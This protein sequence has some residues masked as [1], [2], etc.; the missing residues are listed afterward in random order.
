M[1]RWPRI[2]KNLIDNSIEA[3]YCAIELHNKPIL[4][5]RYETCSILMINAWGLALRAYLYQVA[6]DKEMIKY[7]RRSLSEQKKEIIQRID[8]NNFD[9]KSSF[10][11]LVERIFVWKEN[12]TISANLR[13]IAKLRN[14]FIHANISELNPI[15][16]S[17]LCKCVI[18]YQLFLKRYFKRDLSMESD[19]VLLPIGFQKPVSVTD[20]L[21][22]WM[23]IRTPR[24]VSEIYAISKALQDEWIED[25]ILVNFHVSMNTANKVSNPDLVVALWNQGVPIQKNTVIKLDPNWT[26][27]RTLP[28]SELEKI[29]TIPASSLKSLIKKEW[30]QIKQNDYIPIHRK[31]KSN[32]YHQIFWWRRP[33]NNHIFWSHEWFNELFEEYKLTQ[34]N[35][36][37]HQEN[38]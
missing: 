31:Y 7:L 29:F 19:L 32:E 26:S 2:A 11:S 33:D 16:Y 1:S 23:N 12:K 8:E 37:K 13:C 20:Y 15:L 14:D 9:W 28:V 6:K 3:M 17:L 38:S 25:S 5:Y 35:H 34:K 24:L 27:I 21:S 10:N 18:E 22:W 36:A 30:F 4:Q